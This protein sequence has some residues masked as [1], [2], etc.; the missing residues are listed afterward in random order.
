MY[1]SQNSLIYNYINPIIGDMKVQDITTRVVD[2]H[3]QT[4]QKPLR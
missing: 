2:K 3:I 1:D 4:L